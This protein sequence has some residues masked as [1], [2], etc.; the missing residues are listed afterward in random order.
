M[1]EQILEFNQY[2]DQLIKENGDNIDYQLLA[3]EYLTKVQ[4]YQHERLIHLIVTV[5]FA[6]ME[7]FVMLACVITGH[8]GLMVLA[9]LLLVLLIPYIWHYYFLEN[10][11]QKMY[12][13][14][15]DI[16]HKANHG[17]IKEEKG[18]NQE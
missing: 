13:T 3:A 1:K 18:N 11:V 5:L 15:D 4:F 9:L 6:L 10:T 8:I 2:V 12:L 7:T 16:L 14:Y 17:A